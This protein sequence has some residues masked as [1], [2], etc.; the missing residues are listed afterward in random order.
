MATYKVLISLPSTF[1]PLLA[2]ARNIL[3]SHDFAVIERW[4]DTGIPKPELLELVSDIH[5]FIVGLDI[6]DEDVIAAAPKLKVLSKHGIGTD[7]INLPAATRRGIV[8]TNTPG[9]NASS[10]ADLTIELLICVARQVLQA[11]AIV[12]RG[13]LVPYL[14]PELEGKTLGIIGLGNI[15][16]KVATRALSFGMRVLAN[17]LIFDEAF[18]RENEVAYVSKDEIYRESHFLTLHTPL[19]PL[20]RGM[21]TAKEIRQ[22]RDGAFVINT[23]RGGIV[24]E[25]AVADAL[26]SGKLAGAAFDAFAIEPP[27]PDCGL[28]KAPNVVVTTHM[29]GST[30][31]A[32]QRGGELAAWNII[33]VMTGKQPLSVLNPE[34]FAHLS[35]KS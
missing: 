10:V 5:G 27:P 34:A 23:A 31:E 22:V 6:I 2:S 33:N 26:V 11:E 1:Q 7:N 35:V 4:L 24:D 8:V 18:A 13:Q 20:T 32:I 19:T 3:E 9:S 14:G 25:I 30:P 15:G 28:F 21:I 12:R 17:D 16:K 29:G